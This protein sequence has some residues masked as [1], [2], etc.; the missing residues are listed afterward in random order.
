[1]AGDQRTKLRKRWVRLTDADMI[2]M[3][4]EHDGRRFSTINQ[5]RKEGWSR[6]QVWQAVR[7]GAYIA[8]RQRGST[9]VVRSAR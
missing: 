8:Y 4:G 1:L 5:M 7:Y 3:D 2:R 6:E 9:Q